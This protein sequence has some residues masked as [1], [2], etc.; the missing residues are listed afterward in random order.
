MCPD[1]LVGYTCDLLRQVTSTASKLVRSLVASGL[2]QMNSTAPAHKV[3]C[4][5][6]VARTK[7]NPA[8]P[9]HVSQGEIQEAYKGWLAR[10][11]FVSKMR[12][13]RPVIINVGSKG[14]LATECPAQL[15]G[16]VHDAS[17]ALPTQEVSVNQEM[18]MS[19]MW[20]DGGVREEA[21]LWL[22]HEVAFKGLAQS[23][24]E[25]DGLDT[26]KSF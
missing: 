17:V 6:L 16:V 21:G 13:C 18:A 24:Q 12:R 7:P 5:A 26:F 23:T 19:M 2:D 1:F 3:Y 22:Q 8:E 15:S 4:L 11:G 10:H 14:F 9:M 25:S 20:G